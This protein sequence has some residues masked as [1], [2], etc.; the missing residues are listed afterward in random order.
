M[1]CRCPCRLV[2]ACLP[3][4]PP[5]HTLPGQPPS[6]F[7]DILYHAGLWL[8]LREK[9][10][11]YSLFKNCFNKLPINK[12]DKEARGNYL[13]V[14][15]IK[16]KGEGNFFP[17]HFSKSAGILLS[18]TRVAIL[19]TKP[20]ETKIHTAWHHTLISA[21]SHPHFQSGVFGLLRDYKKIKKYIEKTEQQQQKKAT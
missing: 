14:L 4:P 2:P 11:W 7:L 1:W 19:R 8:L 17:P 10:Q 5:P 16:L 12:R 3:G 18:H 20:S 15:E 21:S 13:I 6:S 9:W